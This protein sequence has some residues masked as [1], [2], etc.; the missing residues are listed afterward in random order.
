VDQLEAHAV[1]LLDVVDRLQGVLDELLQAVLVADLLVHVRSGA[2]TLRFAGSW[3]SRS[4]YSSAARRQLVG[5][6][7]GEAGELEAEVEHLGRLGQGRRV[8][9]VGD[10]PA[11][12][13]GVAAARREREQGPDRVLV[14]AGALAGQL[15]RAAHQ[16]LGARGLAGLQRELGGLAGGLRQALAALGAALEERQ[17][18]GLVAGVAQDLLVQRAAPGGPARPRGSAG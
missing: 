10:R 5:L 3:A 13:A 4:S 6:A 12:V 1:A 2:H 7:G 8:A 18:R 16:G 11:D 15:E 9:Q 17:Q 14:G